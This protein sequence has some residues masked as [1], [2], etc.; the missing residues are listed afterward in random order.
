[1][2]TA[3]VSIAGAFKTGANTFTGIDGI[4]SNDALEVLI[5]WNQGTF[6]KNKSRKFSKMDFNKNVS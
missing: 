1:M 5:F 6:S 2:T 4:T 3:F